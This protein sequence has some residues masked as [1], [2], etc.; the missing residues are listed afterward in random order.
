[1]MAQQDQSK[2]WGAAVATVLTFLALGP[3]LG[4][5]VL[6]LLLTAVPGLALPSPENTGLG[7]TIAVSLGVALFAVP[8][9]Y[10][11]GGLQAL[12]CGVVLAAYGWMKGRPPLWIGLISCLLAYAVSYSID[13]FGTF[14]DTNNI[15]LVMVI[16]H[17]VPAILCW[18]LVRT[19]WR[20]HE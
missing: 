10:I 12:F 13:I 18:L 8:F 20:A 1:M 17:L 16:T 19:Y 15:A 5:I 6:V 9:A 7:T 11:L 4:A 3:L 2:P 14:A